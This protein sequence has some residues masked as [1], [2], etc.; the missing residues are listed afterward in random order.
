M[1]VDVEKLKED[2]LKFLGSLYEIANEHIK[3]EEVLGGV[4]SVSEGMWVIGDRAGL[5]REETDRASTDSSDSGLVLVQSAVDASGP[6][7]SLTP[8][9]CRVAEQY[10]YEKSG[11]AKRRSLLSAVCNKVGEGVL[12]GIKNVSLIAV[13]AIGAT[14]GPPVWRFFKNWIG[15]T[16]PF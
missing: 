5:T 1:K 8:E 16:L 9:G 4:I 12:E 2:R 6:A 15:K 11:L 10:L 13:G 14:Y 7:F 3:S